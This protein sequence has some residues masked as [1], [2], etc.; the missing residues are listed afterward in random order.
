VVPNGV[1]LISARH[2]TSGAAGGRLKQLG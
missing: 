2:L 1:P